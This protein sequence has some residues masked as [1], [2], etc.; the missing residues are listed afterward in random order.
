M[1]TVPKHKLIEMCNHKDS[2]RNATPF[3]YLFNQ[4][5]LKKQNFD[6]LDQV[7]MGIIDQTYSHPVPGKILNNA[8]IRNVF[9]RIRKKHKQN[10]Q[11]PY[12]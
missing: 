4:E 10:L 6:I 2:I 12:S 7:D 3:V 11:R 8:V 1:K 9:I 5:F